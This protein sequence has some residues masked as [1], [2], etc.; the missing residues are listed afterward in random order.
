MT[1]T[2]SISSRKLGYF[3]EELL[4]KMKIKGKGKVIVSEVNGK[5]VI[6]PVQ[7][8]M[9]FAGIIPKNKRAPADFDFRK[10]MEENY[11]EPSRL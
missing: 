4:K 9:D 3:P 7:D 1:Y 6:N 10:Y 8:I 11:N 2:I 5:W